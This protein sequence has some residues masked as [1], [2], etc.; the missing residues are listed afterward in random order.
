MMADNDPVLGVI[1]GSGL[2]DMAGLE[3]V[4]V[5]VGARLKGDPFTGL[6]ASGRKAGGTA[7]KRTG[8]APA[9]RG[10]VR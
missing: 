10:S 2:Y 4:R 8:A 7:R 6:V 9:A 5:E 3:D 1:G